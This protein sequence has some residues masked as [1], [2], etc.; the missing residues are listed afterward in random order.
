MATT[1]TY[2]PLRYPGGKTVYAGLLADVISLN[3]LKDVTLVEPY[4][5]GAGASVKLLLE[6]KVSRLI[7]N[8]LDPAIYAFWWSLTH[9]TDALSNMIYET[10]ITL[11]EWKKQRDISR[12]KD[13]HD[14]LRLGFSADPCGR[15]H[16][17]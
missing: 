17:V 1:R 12:R 8:D 2:T 9:M 13:T 11:E 6:C 15:S 5:G 3:D 4:A 10:P 14:L 16:G 7:L